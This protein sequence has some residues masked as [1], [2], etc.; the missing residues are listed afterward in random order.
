LVH[1]IKT[2]QASYHPL[3]TEPLQGLEVKVP[4]A[5]VSLPRLVIPMS[6]K[7]EGLCYLHVEDIESI[8]ASGYLG[9]KVTMA[10]S[11]PHDS[12]IDLHT[13]TA[14]IQLSQADDRVPQRRDVVD[15]GEQSVLTRLDGEDDGADALD[16]HA[17]GIPKLDGA[18]DIRVKLSEELPS[19]GHVMSDAGVE[20]PPVSLVVVGAVAEEG[21]YSW[22]IKV[23]ES[24]CGRCCWR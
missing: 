12:V 21:M 20:A 16:L 15:S 3:G 8:G 17:G 7:A 19:T 22:L 14:L 13:R 11:N 10:I 5:L 1:V 4:E 9:K 2:R 23:E 18:S 24:R 6:S